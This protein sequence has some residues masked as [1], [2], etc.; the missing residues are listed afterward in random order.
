[1]DIRAI[2]DAD[3][4]VPS[5]N[6]QPIVVAPDVSALANNTVT[7]DA[8]E[9]R[10]NIRL[11]IAQGTQAITDLLQLTRDARTPR[12]YEVLAGMLET[13]AKLNHDLMKVHE[14]EQNLSL[15]DEAVTESPEVHN[16]IEKAVFVG[17]TSELS[18]MMK[19]QKLKD[20]TPNAEGNQSE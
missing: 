9:A 16:H 8:N 10:T 7:K 6:S 13:M 11:L 15:D 2:L 17:S 14:D 18:E 12:S 5:A 1:M 4:P 19:Q 20:I 3:L